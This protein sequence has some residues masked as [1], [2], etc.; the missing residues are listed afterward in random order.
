MWYA[1]DL[2]PQAGDRLICLGDYTSADDLPQG[3]FTEDELEFI[4]AG[5]KPGEQEHR[6]D[7]EESDHHSENHASVSYVNLSDVIPYDRW[8]QVNTYTI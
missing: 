3:A 6:N 2:C 5:M 7:G 8:Q 1:R 4:K